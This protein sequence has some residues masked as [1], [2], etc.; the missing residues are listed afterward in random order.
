MT[1]PAADHDW[2]H[3]LPHLL[4]E[5]STLTTLLSEAELADSPLTSAGIGILDLVHSQPGITVAEIAR[6]TPKTPQAISQVS[7]RLEKLGYL[8]RRL[9]GGRGVALHITPDGTKARTDGNRREAAFDDRLRDALGAD[10]YEQLRTL[11][12]E[13]TPIVRRIN[14]RDPRT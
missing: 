13:A 5:L 4:W 6:R 11:L 7:G 1:D 10:R 3:R 2:A 14:A 9:A 8:E 12:D